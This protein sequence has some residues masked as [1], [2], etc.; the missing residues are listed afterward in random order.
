[1][2]ECDDHAPAVREKNLKTRDS[3]DECKNAKITVHFTFF[4]EENLGRKIS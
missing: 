2:K 3:P 1:M 4:L